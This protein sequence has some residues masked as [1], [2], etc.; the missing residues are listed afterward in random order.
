MLNNKNRVNKVTRYVNTG[1]HAFLLGV[2]AGICIRERMDFR[3][4]QE[5]GKKYGVSLDQILVHFQNALDNGAIAD[6]IDGE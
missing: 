3:N 1:G 4:A 5:L 2:I 6:E